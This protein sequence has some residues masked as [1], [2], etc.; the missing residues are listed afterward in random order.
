VRISDILEAAEASMAQ[1]DPQTALQLC[2]AALARMPD[3][4]GALELKASILVEVGQL[5]EAYVLFQRCVA[6]EPNKGHTKYMYL[7]QMGG[8]REAAAFFEKGIAILEARRAKA[9]KDDEEVRA[10]HACATTF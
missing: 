10:T 1:F 6:L 3:H 9:L 4:L 8:G 7:G 5:P 2:D